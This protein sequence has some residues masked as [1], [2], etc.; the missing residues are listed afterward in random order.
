MGAVRRLF[1]FCWENRRTLVLGVASLICLALGACKF[2]NGDYEIPWGS[3]LL[4]GLGLAGLALASGSGED[5]QQPVPDPQQPVPE[6][7]ENDKYALFD[8]VRQRV[9]NWFKFQTWALVIV[10]GISGFYVIKEAVRGAVDHEFVGIRARVNAV[11]GDAETQLKD[12]RELVVQTGR[13]SEEAVAAA[14]KANKAAREAE[15]SVTET[16][17][18]V[19][20]TKVDLEQTMKTIVYRMQQMEDRQ[21]ETAA[22]LNEAAATLEKAFNEA[23]A[24]LMTELA[25]AEQEFNRKLAEM[26]TRLTDEGARLTRELD[27][28]DEK[29][30]RV[31]GQRTVE[32]LMEDMTQADPLRALKMLAKKGP[33]AEEAI[34]FIQEFLLGKDDTLRSAAV[35]TL[36]AI[37]RRPEVT[38]PFLIEKAL[39]D[40]SAGVRSAACTSLANFG[41]EAGKYGA[42]LALAPML[43]D[44]VEN[45]RVRAATGITEVGGDTEFVVKELVNALNSGLSGR[46][47]I[48][49]QLGTL[50]PDAKDAVDGLCVAV[51]DRD[52]AVSLQA[53]KALGRIGASAAA[54]ASQLVGLATERSNGISFRKAAVDTLGRV[55]DQNV[56]GALKQL[57]QSE[58]ENQEVI[59]AAAIAIRRIEGESINSL[60]ELLKPENSEELRRYAV[61]R[62]RECGGTAEPAVENLME[63]LDKDASWQVRQEA[64][65]T[66][67]KIGFQLEGDTRLK[68]AEALRRIS[69]TDPIKEVREPAFQEFRRLTRK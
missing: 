30:G 62:L 58:G 11:V 60:T 67:G 61:E 47:V 49:R 38:V 57:T 25:L 33:E 18:N 20:V 28:M 21:L 9:L 43:T 36:G 29:L 55:G 69:A 22:Q 16:L 56:V 6:D 45:V 51:R 64:A 26:R 27:R 40:E 34:E 12:A 15:R 48:A 54:A 17:K 7:R 42:A 32:E 50:G 37:R 59:Q 8:D 35:E 10:F 2:V 14:E 41:P 66:L 5:R 53:V 4:V 63:T 52:P 39:V 13:A 44:A 19:D 31:D 23:T 1:P 68:I 24:A 46:D 3:L 65:T